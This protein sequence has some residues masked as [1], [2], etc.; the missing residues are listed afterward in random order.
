MTEVNKAYTECPYCGYHTFSELTIE[1]T[2][3]DGVRIE[4]NTGNSNYDLADG[5]E[6]DSN[7]IETIGYQCL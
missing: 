3:Q 6:A 7:C 4:K 5:V 1:W 2:H